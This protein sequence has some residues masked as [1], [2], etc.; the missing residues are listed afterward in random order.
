MFI[1]KGTGDNDYVIMIRILRNG[2][3]TRCHPPPLRGGDIEEGVLS[4]GSGFPTAGIIVLQRSNCH[5]IPG[6]YIYIYIYIYMCICVCMYLCGNTW[7]CAFLYM[8]GSRFNICDVTKMQILN[9]LFGSEIKMAISL[10]KN[11]S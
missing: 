8:Y 1:N 6:T 3:H 5:R 7:V 11:Y 4:L 9:K 2:E 10:L